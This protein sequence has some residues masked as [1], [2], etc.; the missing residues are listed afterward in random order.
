M[1]ELAPDFTPY[2]YGFNNPVFW[3][4]ATGLFESY[5]AAQSWIDKWGLTGAEISYNGY[6]GVYEISNEGY[7]FY[8]KGEDIIS[9]MYSMETGFEVNIFKGGASADGIAWHPAVGAISMPGP[10]PGS[11]RIT[12]MGSAGDITGAFEMLFGEVAKATENPYA[13][14]ALSIAFN[15]GKVSVSNAIKS[16]SKSLPKGFKETKQFGYQHGQKVYEYKGKY[17]SKDIGSGNGLGSHNGGVWKVFEA[18]GNRLKRVGTAD[19]NLNIFKY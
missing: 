16:G 10:E 17:Y 4:D 12:P 6:K 9:S 1:A 3:Q 8:Q 14:V 19:E 13:G 7:S 11:G 2:R 18:N 15:K 5:G